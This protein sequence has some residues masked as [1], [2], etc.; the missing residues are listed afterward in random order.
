MAFSCRPWLIVLDEPTTGLD[1]TTQRHVL[2]T[3]RNLCSAYGVAAS[4]SAT[5]SPSSAGSSRRWPSCTPG[6]SSSSGRPR[7]SSAI[8]VHPY[9]RGLARRRPVARARRDAARDRGSAAASGTP[10]D[11]M[12]VRTALRAWWSTAVPRGA[13][14]VDRGR[15]IARCGAARASEVESRE[16]RRSGSRFPQRDATGAI[17]RSRWP[18]LKAQL[19]AAPRCCTMSSSKIARRLLR[20]GRG[21]VGLGQDDARPLHRRSAHQL[22]RRASPSTAP[23]CAAG[24]QAPAEGIAAAASSTSSRTPTPRSI[25]ARRSVRSS[26]SRSSTSSISPA[27]S[28]RI[29]RRVVLKDVSLSDRLLRRYPDQLSGGERQRVA[30]ARALVVE[31]ELLVCDEVT[32]ALDVSVQAVIVELLRRLQHER[33]L[34]MIFI[35]HNLA[36]VRSPSPRR[37]WCSRRDRR[38]DRHGRRRARAPTGA[39]HGEADGGRAEAVGRDRIGR[40]CRLSASTCVFAA[41]R[42]RPVLPNK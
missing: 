16:R 36:L 26:L 4:T 33:H 23:R 31:P 21:R 5:T 9:T 24:M 38:R 1:V 17:R 22:D 15:Q 20:R 41:C 39:V 28:G 32:S 2:D 7:R 6:G 11:G 25:R 19:R 3:V 14:A 35:T 18:T 42:R 34:A 12:L 37:S 30:I 27:P 10:A 40:R 8:P 29:A 13:R